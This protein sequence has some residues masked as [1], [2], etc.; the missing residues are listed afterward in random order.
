MCPNSSMLVGNLPP[1][2][3]R[4]VGQPIFLEVEM[5]DM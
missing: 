2:Y 1:F 5:A 3:F 4:R